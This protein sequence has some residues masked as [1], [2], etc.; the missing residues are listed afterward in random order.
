MDLINAA[1]P[2]PAEVFPAR[3]H[4]LSMKP[5]EVNVVEEPR[6]IA[7]PLAKKTWVIGAGSAL[8]VGVG[9]S[10]KILRHLNR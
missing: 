9:L 8:P 3:R 6:L 10:P 4:V 2:L 7:H 5:V 1:L